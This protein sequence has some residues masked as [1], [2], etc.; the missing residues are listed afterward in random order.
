M[1]ILSID[2]GL[3]KTGYAILSDLKSDLKYLTSGLIKTSKKNGIQGRLL[4]IYEQ[5]KKVSDEF[6]PNIIVLE[7]IFYFKNKK[8]I[9]NISQSQGVI[10]LLAAQKKLPI[11]FITPLQIKQTIT[12]YGRADKKSIEKMLSLTFKIDKEIKE[13]DETDAIACGLTYCYLNKSLLQ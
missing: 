7:Q 4:K 1:R 10:L 3:E 8:T 5:L 2:P 9:I 13:D 11:Y 6:K 12:G